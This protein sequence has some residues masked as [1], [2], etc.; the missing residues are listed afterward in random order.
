MHID[1]TNI[2]QAKLGHIGYINITPSSEA[3][4]DYT[5]I[6]PAKLEH[7]GCIYITPRCEAHIAY[8]TSQTLAASI[9]QPA[10]KRI[11]TTLT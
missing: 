1:Y 7:I 3:H 2:T 4:I 6:T 8:T 5:N 9:S 11:L 10:L